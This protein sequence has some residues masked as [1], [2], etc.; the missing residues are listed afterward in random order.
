MK[1]VRYSDLIPWKEVRGELMQDPEFVEEWNKHGAERQE[2]RQMIEANL[3][4][5]K[6]NN[7]SS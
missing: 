4:K 2:T 6:L 7:I 1:K 3:R 5:K